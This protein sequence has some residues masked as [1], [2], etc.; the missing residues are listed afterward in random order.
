M[1]LVIEGKEFIVDIGPVEEHVPEYFDHQ[2]A[3][4]VGCL[5]Y[6]GIEG[7][8]GLVVVDD[9]AAG[10]VCDGA[11]VDT[12]AEGED[13]LVWLVVLNKKKE[14]VDHIGEGIE[15]PEGAIFGVVEE[16]VIEYLIG[17]ASH[18]ILRILVIKL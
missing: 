2:V 7:D 13:G 18:Q 11:L 5:R 12:V 16:Q 8:D 15:G 17:E 10:V 9:G 4:L 14:R 3:P 1:E 6:F